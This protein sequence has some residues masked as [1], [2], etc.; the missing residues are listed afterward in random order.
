MDDKFKILLISTFPPRKC[1]IASFAGDLLNAL[2]PELAKEAEVL[3]YALDKTA[4]A[5]LYEWPVVRLID[6]SSLQACMEAAELI[7]RD[8]SIRLLCFEH[9]FGLYGGDMGDYLLGFLALIE[10]PFV[11]RFHTVLPAPELK[12]LKIVQ[13][14]ALLA[15]KVIV[16]TKHS[17]LLLN[18]VYQVALHKIAI[19]PHGTHLIDTA[20]ASELKEKYH[21]SA[22]LILTTFGLL[23]PN[24]GIET[25]IQAMTEIVRQFPNARYLVLGNTHPNL[26]ASEG[27]AYRKQLQRSIQAAGLTKHVQL[28][29]EYLPTRELMEYLVLTDI[30]LFTSKDPNQAVSGTFLYAMSAGCAIISNSFV[31]AR[32]MLNKETGIIIELGN[33]SEMVKNAVYLLSNDA[34]RKE[35]GNQAFLKTRNT[36]WKTVARKHVKLFS[37]ILREDI[38]IFKQLPDNA[39]Y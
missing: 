29:N 19:I 25:G 37:S 33:T 12:R 35:M 31:L 14:I 7:N 26:L 27:E 4:H 16:M 9:E 11:I 6:S 38:G 34:V 28:I 10:K 18:D 39:T 30:Y 8:N 21:L 3:V 5:G 13:D 20:D 36:I 1:G 17:A 23:S 15:E 22:N 2:Q 32:E 24:K